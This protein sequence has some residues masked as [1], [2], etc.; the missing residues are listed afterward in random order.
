[1]NQVIDNK[2]NP[3]INNEEYSWYGDEG[4]G[5][6][7]TNRNNKQNKTVQTEPNDETSHMLA[8]MSTIIGLII[9]IIEYIY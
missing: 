9:C 3:V 4:V 6:T 2:M 1:M 7:R 5:R 8:T